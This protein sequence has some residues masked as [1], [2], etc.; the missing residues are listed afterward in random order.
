MNLKPKTRQD[1]NFPVGS[2]LIPAHLRGKVH[3]FYQFARQADDIADHL[4][5]SEEEKLENLNAYRQALETGQGPAAAVKIYEEFKG[6]K[7]LTQAQDLLV[8]FTRDAK[9]QKTKTW[10][11]LIDYCRYSAAPVGRFLLLLH[12]EK[13]KNFDASDQLCAVLQILNHLQDIREDFTLRQRIYLPQDMMRKSGVSEA[14]L[15][16]FFT[17]DSLKKLIHHILDQMDLMLYQSAELIDQ[18]HHKYLRLEVRV[19][20]WTAELLKR[21]LRRGDVMAHKVKLMGYDKVKAAAFALI[22]KPLLPQIC[23]L[24]SAKKSSFYMAMRLL[25]PPRRFGMLVLYA[26]CQR[27]DDIADS[28]DSLASRKKELEHWK[29]Y[30]DQPDMNAPLLINL[31]HEVAKKFHLPKAELERVWSGVYQDAQKNIWAPTWSELKDYTRGV[32]GAVG[33]LSLRLF[34]VPDNR[35]DDLAVSVGEALQWTNILR[36]LD[37]DAMRHRCYLP[38]ELLEKAGINPTDPH[39]LSHPNLPQVLTDF[40]AEILQRYEKSQ[41]I[42]TKAKDKNLRP[43][44]IMMCV[45]RSI[46]N[47]PFLPKWRKILISIQ[48]Y[49][50]YP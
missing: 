7:I 38:K 35:F 15:A 21:R 39:L 44:Y 1:E 8:A 20:W 12:G 9:N 18:I 49:L 24:N 30:L 33:I 32:A 14:D 37:E 46:F 11:D 4:A 27:I 6:T 50:N 34:G 13:L 43:V 41:Q 17:N 28:N 36:D 10:D 2:I 23:E 16:G 31:L 22:G 26:Y 25:P 29:K 19:I 40:K 42:L 5:W 47:R 48:A 45:Y 3:D